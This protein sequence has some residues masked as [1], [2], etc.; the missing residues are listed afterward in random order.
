MSY[1]G[2]IRPGR[3][4]GL[5]V[6]CGKVTAAEPQTC[7]SKPGFTDCMNQ[8]LASAQRDCGSPSGGAWKT[9]NYCTYDDCV[10]QRRRTYQ[11]NACSSVFCD[12]SWQETPV[13]D[14]PCN[15]SQQCGRGFTCQGAQQTSF[16][17]TKPGTCVASGTLIDTKTA[18][19][20]DLTNRLAV[21]DASKF[22]WGAY[23]AANLDLQKRANAAG[24]A[25]WKQGITKGYCKI[26][27]DGKLGSG[28]CGAARANGIATPSTC[29]EFATD[30]R[31]T[32]VGDT[33]PAPSPVTPPK[34]IPYI[35][36][37][38]LP[39]P[40]PI[41]EPINVKDKNKYALILGVVT[42]VVSAV[43]K[44]RGF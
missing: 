23:S 20:K 8:Q 31:G 12:T 33:K 36:P 7:W 42:G 26:T 19:T 15:T 40:E 28:T 1:S 29:R 5:G 34:P 11:K 30:C 32:F 21:S 24:Y 25:R 4:V 2:V 3:G 38:P 37:Q 17:Y 13:K 43:L 14:T 16:G 10:Q 18:E 22:P 39:E 27:E 44:T 6:D 35:Q 9:Q 41:P